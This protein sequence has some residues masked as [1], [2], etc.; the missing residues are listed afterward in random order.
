MPFCRFQEERISEEFSQLQ[1]CDIYDIIYY[2]DI[3]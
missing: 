1:A 2:Y 3:L